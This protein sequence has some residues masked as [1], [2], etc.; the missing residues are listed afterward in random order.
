MEDTHEAR[1]GVTVVLVRQVKR[2]HEG[3]YEAWLPKIISA[4]RRSPGFVGFENLRPVDGLQS[5]YVLILRF[6]SKE[7]LHRWEVSPERKRWLTE[8]TEFTEN[9]SSIQRISGL[10]VSSRHRVRA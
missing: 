6:D 3:D 2:G 10:E 7:N 5:E 1:K 4:M 9:L 8:S